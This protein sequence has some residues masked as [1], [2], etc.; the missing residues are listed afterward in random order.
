MA[1]IARRDPLLLLGDK[2]SA[3]LLICVFSVMGEL[4]E[5]RDLAVEGRELRI[6]ANHL[7]NRAG[8]LTAIDARSLSF[9]SKDVDGEQRQN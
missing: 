8:S 6:H 2:F 7:L 4:E 3:P 1:I 9:F 5:L